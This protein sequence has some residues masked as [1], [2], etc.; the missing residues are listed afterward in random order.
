MPQLTTNLFHY[1]NCYRNKNNVRPFIP[2]PYKFPS[3]H[4]SFH[5][6]IL[7]S[8]KLVLAFV[9]I[10]DI[11]IIKVDRHQPPMRS[12]HFGSENK[13]K[14]GIEVNPNGFILTN[15]KDGRLHLWSI[16]YFQTCLN[17]VRKLSAVQDIQ[18]V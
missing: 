5:P 14:T 11:I 10:T 16:A 15:C 9:F 17:S 12:A 4:S 7:H 2:P 8:S 3:M 1:C 13:N 18:V 6:S